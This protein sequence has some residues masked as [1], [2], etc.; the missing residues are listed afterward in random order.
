MGLGCAALAAGQPAEEPVVAYATK[1]SASTGGF[2][3]SL[4][5]ND[6]IGRAIASLGDLNGD[7]IV[8]L[9]V[10]GHADDDGGLDQGAVHVLFLRPDGLVLNQSK[11]SALRGGFAGQLDPGDQ[12]GRS[13][14]YL[15]DIDGDG[16]GEL[17]VGANYDDDGG[18]DRGAL[19]LLSLDATGFVTRT[20]K[21]SSLE[22][23]LVGPLRNHD[24][25]GRS[26]ARIGDLDGDGR[27]ELAVG[28]P[29]DSTGGTRRGAVWILFLDADGR[30]RREVKL[31]SGRNGLGPL[32]NLDWFGFSVA[33]LGDF[34]GDGVPDLVVG[35]ALDDDGAV[36][37][38]AV[39]LLLLRADGTV[40]QR[41]KISTL[42]GGFTGVLESPD[43]FG[44][45][46][47][48]V[49]DLD[50]NGVVDLAVG[51]VKDGDGGPERGAVWMLYLESDGRVRFHRKISAT[52]GGF[53]P[54]LDNWDWLGS[55]LAPLAD[56]DGDGV[57]DLAIGARN[58][59]DGASNCGA[60]YLTR[61]RDGTASHEPPEDV[62]EDEV[63][64]DEDTPPPDEVADEDTGPDD[65]EPS[66]VLLTEPLRPGAAHALRARVPD[67]FAERNAR[68]ML[69]IS[70][71][72]AVAPYPPHGLALDPRSVLLADSRA[73]GA[74]ASVDLQL[75]VP[76]NPGLIGRTLAIQTLWLS[77]GESRTS[78]VLERVI[79]P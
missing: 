50:G 62:D 19:W 18:M 78:D 21:I 52:S 48:A 3:L 49:G 57:P 36:N 14:A 35:A 79:A 59:D 60:L 12:F 11:L 65:H 46:V 6:Q 28:A 17:A 68:A 16:I 38:G 20:R 37:A 22:G 61:L 45:S 51:A 72:P 47:A 42:S 66:L 64:Q 71:F 13:L 1:I 56:L 75:A 40:K 9:A 23:G 27:P 39:Y 54:R 5:V 58:D 55:A 41:H 24:E 30:V 7:G 34:D 32:R 63:D 2:R 33:P 31:A 77:Q 43:Q 69:L 10:A 4:S 76:A 74:G 8:D 29:T 25:F 73:A 53:A 15:G 70:P 44:T 67:A 26:V